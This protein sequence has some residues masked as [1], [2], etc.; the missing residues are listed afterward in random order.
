MDTSKIFDDVDELVA[1][2]WGNVGQ[3]RL[4]ATI[5][6]WAITLGISTVGWY[7]ISTGWL[8]FIEDNK[9]REGDICVFQPSKSKGRVNLIFHPL[10]TNSKKAPGSYLEHLEYF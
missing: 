8:D 7:A 3:P 1:M 6:T 4:F 10:E 2:V 9:L 5:T